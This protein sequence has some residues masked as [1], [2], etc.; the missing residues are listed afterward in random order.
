MPGLCVL[1]KSV[2][3]EVD[4]DIF[5]LPGLP[6][7]RFGLSGIYSARAE[8]NSVIQFIRFDLALFLNAIVDKHGKFS[9]Y[10]L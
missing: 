4:E 1:Y 5:L 10:N 2:L 7:Y 6:Q 8:P 9:K 3:D